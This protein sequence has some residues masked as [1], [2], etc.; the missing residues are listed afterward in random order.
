MYTKDAWLHSLFFD[1]PVTEICC[2]FAVKIV[3]IKY[4]RVSVLMIW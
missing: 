1:S 2:K 4:I 3:K